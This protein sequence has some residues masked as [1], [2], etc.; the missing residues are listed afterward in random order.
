MRQYEMMELSLSGPE[1]EGS[2]AG[3]DLTAEF[4]CKGCAV[5]VKGFYAGEG[6]YK[7]RYYPEQAGLYEWRTFGIVK[8]NGQIVCEPAQ[9]YHGMVRVNGTHFEYA[10]GTKYLPFGTTVYAMIHQEQKRI[11]ETMETLAKAPF[12]K[13]RFCVF[14]KSYQY[15]QNEPESFPFQKGEDGWNV[16]RPCMEFW[17]KLETHIAD[18]NRLGIEAD[19][20]LFHPYDR[21]GFAA[22]TKAECMTYL[23]YLVRRLAAFP[24]IWWSLANE[25]DL[26]FRFEESWW[27]EFAAFIH[28]NDVYGHC[29]SNH[30][31]VK[32]WDFENEDTTHC[33]I[34][35]NC[36]NDV[37][38]LQRKYQKPVIFDECGYEGDIHE[39]WGNLSA[40]ELVHRFWTA[41]TLGGYCSHGETYLNDDEVLW[42]SKGGKLTGGSPSR[43]GF[44]KDILY[45]LPGVLKCEYGALEEF[46]MEEDIEVLKKKAETDEGIRTLLGLPR[47]MLVL[48]E[49][50]V[51]EVHGYVSEQV[52]LYYYGRQC[53]RKGK[54]NLP[55]NN[56]YRIEVIDIWNM[57]RT[58]AAEKASGEVW[59][60]MPGKEG[61][62]LLARR[63]DIL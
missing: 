3:V 11:T 48:L 24:N 61:I 10:D 34:Q 44:L 52:Y 36:M 56:A 21:W 28:E 33:C 50:K 37:K 46:L 54:M 18:L 1:P 25:Y 4:S 15:N 7:I 38:L 60:E 58:I 47:D 63:A 31:F 41:Y 8:E 35:D 51:T 9:K 43:I 5:L 20:I 55:E 2:W 16:H 59:V 27:K 57:T 23:E 62:A 12:N 30:N 29:L 26:M 32:Y 53:A 6:M 40:F 14:P 22:M 49:K 13:V 45:S 17:D 42:W 19:L 39:S